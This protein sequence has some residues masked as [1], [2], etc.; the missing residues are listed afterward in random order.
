MSK[1]SAALARIRQLACL[2]LPG[3]LFISSLLPVLRGLTESDSAAFFWLDETGGIA[4]KLV[5]L[6]KALV[7]FVRG[8]LLTLDEGLKDTVAV[9]NLAGRVIPESTYFAAPQVDLNE[10]FVRALDA[11]LASR[12][13]S[14][15]R[16]DT[17][18]LVPRPGRSDARL[19]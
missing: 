1:K 16:R 11:C 15:H 18:G 5:N 7:G 12:D 6:A 3:G 19:G 14:E 13:W 9:V 10:E 2:G 8:G 17:F 4:T